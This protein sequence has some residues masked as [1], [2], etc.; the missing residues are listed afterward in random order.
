MSRW[1]RAGQPR[2]HQCG[3]AGWAEAGAAAPR[4]GERPQEC[5]VA[6]LTL[7]F[8]GCLAP[9]ARGPR[10]R[11]RS[12]GQGTRPGRGPRASQPPPPAP[13]LPG[14]PPLLL[15][16][17]GLHRTAQR[18]TCSSGLGGPLDTVGL[19]G[20]SRGWRPRLVVAGGPI[21]AWPSGSRRSQPA[22]S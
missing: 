9:G 1:G 5:G 17:R 6:V 15:H 16:L 11:A 8:S 19:V 2:T 3:F 22:R 13:V 7:T 10:S 21:E 12:L 20:S 4:P 14:G 18:S